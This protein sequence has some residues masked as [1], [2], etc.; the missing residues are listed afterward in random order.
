MKK[1]IYALLFLF[2]FSGIW[3]VK[4]L[5][6]KAAT[7]EYKMQVNADTMGEYDLFDDFH[8]IYE[9]TDEITNIKS[10]NPSIAYLSID[11]YEDGEVEDAYVYTNDGTV[12]SCDLSFECGGDTYVIHFT[13]S[14]KKIETTSVKMLYSKG[15]KVEVEDI[16]TG[17]Y[18]IKKMTS[19]AKNVV[20]VVNKDKIV[21]KKAG[22]ATITYFGV[23]EDDECE[24]YIQGQINIQVLSMAEVKKDAIAK[25]NKFLAKKSSKTKIAY[26]DLDFDGIKDIVA[27]KKIYTY[28]KDTMKYEATF[29]AKGSIYISKSKKRV[30]F[31][32]KD[33]SKGYYKGMKTYNI[34]GKGGEFYDSYVANIPSKI[35]K[36]HKVSAKQKYG[37]MILWD[38][39][40]GGGFEI[41]GMSKSKFNSAIK[42]KMPGKKLVKT[43][44]NT[45]KNRKNLIK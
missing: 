1:M 24:V 28:N 34:Y 18:T 35:K 39:G 12:G 2:A 37:R 13:V 6:T 25:A 27:G 42:K 16:I 43:Y 40:F 20:G 7:K 17:N 23:E 14:A 22:K 3:G 8:W 33:T 32:W 15:K 41:H 4:A 11:Q 19:S 36:Y 29:D 26:V 9:L 5:D 30:M 31:V 44:A 10:S 38:D 21:L 45:A